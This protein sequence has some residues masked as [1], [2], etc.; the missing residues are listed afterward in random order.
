MKY[1]VDFDFKLRSNSNTKFCITETDACNAFQALNKVKSSLRKYLNGESII[2]TQ[3]NEVS[4]IVKSE[5]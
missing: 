2:I 5:V 4:L 1:K 3:I